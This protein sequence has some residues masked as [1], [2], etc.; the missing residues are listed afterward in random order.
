MKVD[1]FPIGFGRAIWSVKRGDTEYAIEA[2]PFGGYVR[3]AGMNP[4]EEIPPQDRDRVFKSKPGWQQA[5][6]LAAGSFTHFFVAFLIAVA[7]FS[8]AGVPDKPTLTID[9][10]Q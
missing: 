7:V 6:V 5:I 4:M 1:R 9:T 2:L 3:I 8:I 10:V